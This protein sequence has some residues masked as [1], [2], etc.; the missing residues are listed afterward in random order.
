MSADD[1]A[2]VWHALAN[3]HRRRI[4]DV[5]RDGPRTTG[6]IAERLTEVSRFAVMQHL[7]VL[8]G[9]DLVVVL[10]HGRERWN[11]VNPVP[12]RRIYE[13]W[14]SRFEEIWSVDLAALK[15]ASESSASAA[16]SRRARK[17]SGGPP[18]RGSTQ[19]GGRSGPR[20]PR[21]AGSSGTSAAR[22]A[23]ARTAA[24]AKEEGT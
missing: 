13:R 10:R 23:A 20:D 3:P 8:V 11:H 19:A 15:R 2:E 21:A 7:D 4:L 14:V 16:K 5:L 1:L 22:G 9:A 18:A 6:A 24:V 17:A 12:I